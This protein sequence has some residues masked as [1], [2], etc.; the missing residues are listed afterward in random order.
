MIICPCSPRKQTFRFPEGRTCFRWFLGLILLASVSC[1]KP[2]RAKRY[3]AA[4]RRTY[5]QARASL[6]AGEI[7]NAER[8]AAKSR[9]LALKAEAIFPSGPMHDSMEGQLELSQCMAGLFEDPSCSVKMWLKSL[10]TQDFDLLFFVFDHDLFTESFYSARGEEVSARQKEA[11]QHGF[12]GSYK[13]TLQKYGEFFSSWKVDDLE[14]RRD[15]NRAEVDLHLRLLGNEQWMRFWLERKRK[16]WMIQ[17]FSVSSD[18]KSRASEVMAKAAVAL[19]DEVDVVE[20]FRGKGIFE[21]FAEAES[22]NVFDLD[23]WK[24]PLV[25]HYVRSTE[26]LEMSRNGETIP[27]PPNT[28][29]KVVQQARSDKSLLFVRTTEVSP[30]KRAIGQVRVENTDYEGT[31]ETS[32]WGVDSLGVEE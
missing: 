32:L 31:D 18:M 6:L 4:S 10:A 26:P 16:I 8:L 25:G 17:D 7:G 24:N 21:A 11:F 1:S 13:R 19:G 5:H 2:A 29:L 14:T 9:D 23:S 12:L 22:L 15:G 3:I 27:V 28:I 20:I 30:S